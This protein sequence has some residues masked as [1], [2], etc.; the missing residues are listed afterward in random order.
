LRRV[1]GKI[2]EAAGQHFIPVAP[3][4]LP[5]LPRLTPDFSFLS[6]LLSLICQIMERCHTSYFTD[7]GWEAVGAGQKITD[8]KAGKS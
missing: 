3:V 6:V 1:G 7:A 8:T 4:W 2:S 5:P